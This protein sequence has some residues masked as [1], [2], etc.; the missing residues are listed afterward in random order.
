MRDKELEQEEWL[1]SDSGDEGDGAKGARAEGAR[2]K[3]VQGAGAEGVEGVGAEGV[4]G[5]GAEGVEGQEMVEEPVR[6]R[7]RRQAAIDGVAA[8][9][10]A[11]GMN[12]VDERPDRVRGGRLAEA[13]RRRKEGKQ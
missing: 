9:A 3:G 5:A 11:A 6:R 12:D 8:A 1:P 4:E 7:S 13:L 2:A 10:F